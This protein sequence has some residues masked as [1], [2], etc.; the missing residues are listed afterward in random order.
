MARRCGNIH[1]AIG[2]LLLVAAFLLDYIL[3][4]NFKGL[5]SVFAHQLEIY[6]RVQNHSSGSELVSYGKDS[7][8][9][10][11][12]WISTA[13]VGSEGLMKMTEYLKVTSTTA[14]LQSLISEPIQKCSKPNNTL[15]KYI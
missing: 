12:I 10:Q 7:N 13:G 5:V 11:S 2:C 4:W 9:G 6:G 14:M 15:R 8:V 3:V 1:I